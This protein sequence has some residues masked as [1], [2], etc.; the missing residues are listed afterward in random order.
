MRD[1]EIARKGTETVGVKC[2]WG[3]Q[4]KSAPQREGR[5]SSE[6]EEGQSVS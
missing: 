4:L 2:I 3:S 5:G 1:G 6:S